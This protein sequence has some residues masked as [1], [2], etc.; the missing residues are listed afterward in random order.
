[1]SFRTMEVGRWSATEALSSRIGYARV[2]T[3]HQNLD[4]QIDALRAA[5]CEKIFTD[6]MT[7]SRL[8]GPVTSPK[9]SSWEGRSL[10]SLSSLRRGSLADIRHIGAS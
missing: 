3:L 9:A 6:K 2:G 7:G 10:W 5:G 8:D 4:S 1:M